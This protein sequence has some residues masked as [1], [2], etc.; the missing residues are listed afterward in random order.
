MKTSFPR[1]IVLIAFVCACIVTLLFS[2]RKVELYAPDYQTT[3]RF[4]QI[5]A[6]TKPDVRRVAD[7]MKRQNAK[8][9]FITKV[10]SEYGFA[11]WNKSKV[12]IEKQ[13][14][15]N[16]QKGAEENSTDT[17][18]LIPLVLP[19]NSFVNGFIEA[20]ISDTTTVFRILHKDDYVNFPFG[21]AITD[22]ITADKLATVVM[23]FDK[24]VFNYDEFEILD[25]RLFTK[26][27][28]LNPERTFARLS[29]TSD[30][31][32]VD[33]FWDPSP[34]NHD[35]GDEKYDHTE[36][37][38]HGGSGGNV[39]GGGDNWGGGNNGGSY[40]Q[41]GSHGGSGYT[42][43]LPALVRVNSLVAFLSLDINKKN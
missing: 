38:C 40:F 5:P 41:S 43:I 33:I 29:E 25:R 42:P 11:L 10:T 34:K 31:Y 6:N 32:L 17:I 18:V 22:E 13:Q 15:S 26:D 3:E 16:A 21:D 37:W 39:G 1:T 19:D 23:E 20:K 4:F 2:C 30:C 8:S 14:T 36:I 35:T 7:E 12:T 28:I 27:N 24:E 9:P